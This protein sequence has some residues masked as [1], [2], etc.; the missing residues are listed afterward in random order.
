MQIMQVHMMSSE[1]LEQAKKLFDAELDAA[2]AE[3]LKRWKAIY[4]KSNKKISIAD[5]L[6][7][8][9]KHA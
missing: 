4:E 2:E 3:A 9:R 1:A 7:R 8:L 5:L 6:K